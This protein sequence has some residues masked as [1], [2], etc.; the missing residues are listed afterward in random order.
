[1][2]RLDILT[3]ALTATRSL[4]IL[5]TRS[6][7]ILLTTRRLHILTARGLNILTTGRL[8]ILLTTGRLNVLTARGLN[9]L[10]TRSLDI[11]LTTGRLNVL[12]TR[13]LNILATRGLLILTSAGERPRRLNI[14][15]ARRLNILPARGLNILTARRLNILPARGLNILTPRS[16]L[17]LTS[18]GERPRR[19]NILALGDPAQHRLRLV[20]LW[21]GRLSVH[22]GRKCTEDCHAHDCC[23]KPFHRSLVPSWLLLRWC[24]SDCL[25]FPGLRR[26]FTPF[27]IERSSV[28]TRILRET[29][30]EQSRCQVIAASGTSAISVC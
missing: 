6:L 13:G 20:D 10:T 17:I 11:L 9:I 30:S 22:R 3:S 29:D 24:R 8:D 7:D 12:T 2:R 21:A 18:A 14:L 27:P 5:T 19:L 26:P 23:E 25:R 28:G 4:N 16:L 15:T 1:M